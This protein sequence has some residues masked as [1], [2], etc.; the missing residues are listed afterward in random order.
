MAQLLIIDDEAN[1]RAALRCSLERLGHIVTEA[2]DGNEGLALFNP[3]LHDVIVTDIVMPG[4][5]GLALLMEVRKYRG[6]TKVIAMSGGGMFGAGSY[7]RTAKQMGADAILAKPF[8]CD[9]LEATLA[10]VLQPE[11]ATKNK[12]VD[13]VSVSAVSCPG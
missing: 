12:A 6:A 1:L 10:G 4:T 7:L 5:E 2:G 8:S 11:S 13:A 9:E 3:A